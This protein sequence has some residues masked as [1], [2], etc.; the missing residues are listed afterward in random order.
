MYT[1]Y[2]YLVIL[3]DITNNLGKNCTIEE[4]FQAI[5]KR[6]SL[7][8]QKFGKNLKILNAVKK[9]FDVWAGKAIYET[10]KIH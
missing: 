4:R 1:A 9:K 10:L 8:F 2:D 6:R 7:D 3:C 5:F